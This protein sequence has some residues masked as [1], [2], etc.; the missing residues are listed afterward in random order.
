ML[1]PWWQ[2]AVPQ[3]N[4]RKG[5]IDESIF[6]AK[7][8]DVINDRGVLDYR[9]P[10]LFFSGTYLTE[11][12]C[13]LLKN[14]CKRLKGKGGAPVIRV[15]TPFAGGKTHSL[16]AVFHLFH[17]REK[18]E[19]SD[20]WCEITKV[21][22]DIPKAGIAVIDGE[23]FDILK[24][25]KHG[26]IVT[27]TLWGEIIFQLGGN[28]S[29]ER[30][31]EHDEKRICPGKDILF[32]ILEELQPFVILIDEFIHHLVKTQALD[33]E[34]GTNLTE[35][36][37]SF[38]QHLLEI[39]SSLEKAV[40]II[41][42]PA[43]V[44]EASPE[45]LEKAKRILGR[46]ES[47]ETPVKGEEV[48]EVIRRRLFET[49]GDKKEHQKVAHHFFNMYRSLGDDIPRRVREITYREKIAKAFPFHPEMVDVLMEKWGPHPR[50][51][52]TRGALRFLALV[53]ADLFRRKDSSPLILP[54]NVNMGNSFIQ[55]ELIKCIGDE[56]RGAIALDIEKNAVDIDNELIGDFAKYGLAKAIATS[57]FLHTGTAEG[58]KGVSLPSIRL[59]VLLEKDANPIIS[60]IMNRLIRNL[61]YLYF[62]GDFYW[63]SAQPNINKIHID[64]KE[65]V[66]SEEI[67]EKI[68]SLLQKNVGKALDICLWPEEPKDVPDTPRVKLV[69][70]PLEV[71]WPG[72]KAENY[73]NNFIENYATTF[74]KFKNALIFLAPDK[75]V[76]DNL[77]ETTRE[78]IAFQKI[79]EDVSVMR[80]LNEEQKKM[81][82]NR[83]R[84][85]GRMCLQTLYEC[86][87]H[88]ILPSKEGVKH[89]DLSTKVYSL[90]ENLSEKVVKFLE[91]MQ[92]L[93]PKVDPVLL[94]KGFSKEAAEVG[95]CN[96]RE[97]YY[98][99]LSWKHLPMLKGERSL[100]KSVREGVSQGIFGLGIG[101][102]ESFSQIYYAE[103][104]E[105]S[106]ETGEG[107]WLIKKEKLPE[108]GV[109]PPEIVPIEEEIPEGEMIEE[110]VIELPS[111]VYKNVQITAE[112]P[113]DKF[114]EVFAGVIRPLRKDVK[115]KETDMKITLN[116]EVKSESGIKPDTLDMKVEETLKQIKAKYRIEKEEK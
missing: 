10:V 28:K 2:V 75:K 20:L 56:F 36:T 114:P 93:L 85:S 7:L 51:Q 69:I 67:K 101:D 109:K 3:K 34:E 111:K 110:E 77:R 21:L 103:E 6:V 16:I 105:R 29:Y 46:V 73:I 95:M 71:S 44:Y 72:E 60:D 64:K 48:Y 35:G 52:R 24:G 84:E 33:R 31:K 66:T 63:F 12:L 38:L 99:F 32:P 40:M 50:F 83:A 62:E 79:R 9:D 100:I 23:E 41:S 5:E 98:N 76:V 37:L 90:A 59:C 92:E 102:G 49:L 42:L 91:D 78:L 94:L 58:K 17:N 116:V 61:W 55:E 86:Y 39:V 88:V 57:I 14:I 80:T 96:L 11:G 53:V 43:S 89:L 68:L 15:E 1:K 97:L 82:E 104:V 81:L 107:F 27:Q 54:G 4:I 47:I 74:R 112:I 113:W 87:R 26:D 70:L 115:G 65:T 106:I 25:K 108:L 22:P 30:I 45:L 8:G 13:R 18:L 19:G